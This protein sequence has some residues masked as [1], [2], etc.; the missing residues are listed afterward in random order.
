MRTV[1]EQ[2]REKFL[3]AAIEEL[4]EHGI[5]DFSIRQVAR[6]CGLTSGAPYRHFKSKSELILEA[7]KTVNRAWCGVQ[8]EV[9]RSCG[10]SSSP[11][12]RLVE[13]SLAYVRFLCEHPAYQS[14]LMLND[15]SMEPEQLC[16][17]AKMTETSEKIID[18]YCLEKGLGS[19]ARERKTFAVRSFIYGAALM[20]NSGQFRSNEATLAL[21]RA[22]IEREFDLA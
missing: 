3:N 13:I 5:S 8:E 11:R 10:A 12:E 21:V 20:L 15:S 16:E 22:C 19:E 7:M 14:V 2:N 4:A 18:G 9:I 17:K 6:R 1:N